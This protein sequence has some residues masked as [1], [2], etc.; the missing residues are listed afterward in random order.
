MRA[1]LD[2]IKARFRTRMQGTL[3]LPAEQMLERKHGMFDDGSCDFI[4]RSET[5]EASALCEKLT[6]RRTDT[7]EWPAL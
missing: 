5:A 6:A 2:T 1:D 4:F 7:E 3:P